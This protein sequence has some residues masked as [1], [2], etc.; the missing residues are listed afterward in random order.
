MTFPYLNAMV[1]EFHDAQMTIDCAIE[2]VL[3]EI[4]S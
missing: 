4:N 2:Y 3:V 1:R